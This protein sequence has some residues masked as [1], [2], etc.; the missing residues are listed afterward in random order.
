MILRDILVENEPSFV[1]R[2]N[3]PGVPHGC[4]R[5][6]NSRSGSQ[7]DGSLVFSEQHSSPLQSSAK[8]LLKGAHFVSCFVLL[9]LC[10]SRQAFRICLVTAMDKQAQAQ[11]G[12]TAC[13]GF[14]A[15]WGSGFTQPQKR[16]YWATTG[17]TQCSSSL[18][19]V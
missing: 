3:L 5:W 14:R 13:H 8:Q 18:K 10:A 11:A 2:A 6:P 7:Q 12:L 16:L 19:T 9:V 1:K 4:S 17:T 15:F